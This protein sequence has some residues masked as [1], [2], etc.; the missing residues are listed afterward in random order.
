M[1]NKKLTK[2]KTGEKFGFGVLIVF[3]AMAISLLSFISEENKITGFAALEDDGRD[4]MQNNIQIIPSNLIEF[5]E[6]KSLSTLAPGNYFIDDDGIVYWTDD[7]SRPAIAI[8]NSHDETY[9]NRNI[10]IDDNGN[11][12]YV[13]SSVL[14]NENSE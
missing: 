9:E 10:Y 4:A 3:L 7:E 6:V 11:I 8:V 1:N 5:D 14:I 2:N 12:G 13:L